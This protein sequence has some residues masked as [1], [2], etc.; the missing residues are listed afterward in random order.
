VRL[1]LPLVSIEKVL[2]CQSCTI[3]TCP[4]DRSWA[5]VVFYEARVDP[6]PEGVDICQQT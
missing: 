2:T 1:A 6:G 3:P 5:R 4:C